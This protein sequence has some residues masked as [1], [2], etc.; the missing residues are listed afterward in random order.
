MTRRFSPSYS[1]CSVVAGGQGRHIK[2]VAVASRKVKAGGAGGGRKQGHR[3]YEGPVTS[4]NRV[5][6]LTVN[7]RSSSL[8]TWQRE[9]TGNPRLLRSGMARINLAYEQSS[10]LLELLREYS[11]RNHSVRG[12]MVY[13]WSTDSLAPA[14][15]F[16]ISSPHG[17][18]RLFQPSFPT[19][20]FSDF[21]KNLARPRPR[22][23]LMEVVK[24]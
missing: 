20:L 22:W 14:H 23:K 12:W 21:G 2:T 3:I 18:K 11:W 17:G 7:T 5:P 6:D 19:Y 15:Q 13:D 1:G 9:R 16:D 10:A 24:R 8:Y 4:V